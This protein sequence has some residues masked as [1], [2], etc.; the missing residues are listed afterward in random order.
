MGYGIE[1]EAWYA[2]GSENSGEGCMQFLLHSLQP[3]STVPHCHHHIGHNSLFVRATETCRKSALMQQ[4][5]Y[6]FIFFPQID[7]PHCTLETDT[8]LEQL[9]KEG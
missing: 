4:S 2:L 5:S 7:L 9:A 3:R 8:T 6:N 1:Q